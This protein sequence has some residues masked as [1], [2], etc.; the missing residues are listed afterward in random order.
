M[1]LS[2][3]VQFTSLAARHLEGKPY[4]TMTWFDTGTGRKRSPA[5]ISQI[6]ESFCDCISSIFFF[7]VNIAQLHSLCE[8]LVLSC[9]S[10]G[11]KKDIVVNILTF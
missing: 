11:T 2:S 10:C 9:T 1:T 3:P 5:T 6:L 4:T 7:F 8:M